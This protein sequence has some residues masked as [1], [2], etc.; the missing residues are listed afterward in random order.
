MYLLVG[1]ETVSIMKILAN[2]IAVIE[3]DDH[4]SKW[5]EEGGRLCHDSMVH[6]SILPLLKEGDWVVDAGAFI[7]DHTIAYAEKVGITGNVL[8]FEVSV[9]ALSCL[10]HNSEKYPQIKVYPMGLGDKPRKVSLLYDDLNKGATRI[11][12]FKPGPIKI[13]ALDSLELPQLNFFKIDV[14]GVEGQVLDGAMATISKYRPIIL[15]EINSPLLAFNGE[16]FTSISIR[17]SGLNYSFRDA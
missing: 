11:N 16:S 5:V 17:M 15:L 9:N 14:E 4:I 6:E 2:N 8:A 3:G 1:H 7:G 10:W 12:E 13:V